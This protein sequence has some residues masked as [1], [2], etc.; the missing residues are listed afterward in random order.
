MPRLEAL[1]DRRIQPAAAVVTSDGA[2]WSWDELFD[3][4]AP[5]IHAFA[6]SRGI[7]SPEDIV[8]DVFATA[9]ER[10]PRFDG[11][12]S[13]LRSF[14]FTL[15]Y[16]RI[17]DEHRITH[18]R[19][20]RLVAD[21][22]HTPDERP[23]IEDSLAYIES[24][25][26]AMQALE[27][28]G[29]KERRVI[30]MR[31]I[32]E[33]SPAEVAEALGLSNGNVRVIQARSL[34]KIRKYL[35]SKSGS[36]PSISLVLA[37]LEGLRSELP[38]DRGLAAWIETIRSEAAMGTVKTAAAGGSAVAAG[39]AS[40]ATIAGTVLKVGLVVALATG[41][42]SSAEPV[43]PDRQGDLQL[44]A[45][46]APAKGQMVSTGLAVPR[47]V[48]DDP[49]PAIEV[50]PSAP[51][52]PALV[53]P[54]RDETEEPQPNQAIAAETEVD[55]ANPDTGNGTQSIGDDHVEP[56]VSA[57]VE[58]VTDEVGAVVDDV[59]E[60]VEEVVEEVVE[61]V[62]EVV[63]EV[64]ETVEETVTVVEEVA[65]GVVEVVDETTQTVNDTVD[66]VVDDLTDGLGLGDN[67]VGGLLG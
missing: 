61:V 27:I 38:V 45:V 59:V 10:F 20:E 5:A 37:F 8:Q 46:V 22:P 56:V 57:V 25:R 40:T 63:A 1:V 21:H 62:E 15:V 6:R 64:E 50:P 4:F 18:R 17:A 7:S 67:P 11:D 19:P 12:S 13:G 36:L 52:R 49:T 34:M 39:T 53:A 55:V 66:S 65:E 51:N 33:A 16:R 30:E 41:S 42:T 44:P 14:L 43:S 29:E 26:E 47:A 32:D 48:I 35:E 31:I 2:A 58:P 24:A 9:V 54:T 23:G 3:Q 28:L 60:T